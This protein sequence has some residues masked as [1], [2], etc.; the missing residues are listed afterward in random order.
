MK[1]TEF[2]K[3]QAEFPKKLIPWIG[4]GEVISGVMSTTAGMLPKEPD[5]IPEG[6]EIPVPPAPPWSK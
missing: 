3:K 5:F 1:P 4:V 2:L 6:P